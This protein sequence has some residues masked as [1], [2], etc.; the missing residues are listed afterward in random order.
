MNLATVSIVDNPDEVAVREKVIA[1][2]T[3]KG[4]LHTSLMQQSNITNLS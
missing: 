4:R 3:N 2:I 1:I